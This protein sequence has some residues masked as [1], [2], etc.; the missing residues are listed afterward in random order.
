MVIL[1]LR[2]QGRSHDAHYRIVAQEKRSKLNGKY[3]EAIGHYHPTAKDNEFTFDKER[4]EHW[5]KQG[6]QVSDSVVNLLVKAGLLPKD[7]KISVVYSTK[8]K[9]AAPAAK[10]PKEGAAEVAAETTEEPKEEPKDEPKDEVKEE[11]VEE[12]E[13]TVE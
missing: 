1:R 13:K 7:R 11:V 8:K 2:R 6:A 10:E 3:I 5:L 12:A 9:E 4:V